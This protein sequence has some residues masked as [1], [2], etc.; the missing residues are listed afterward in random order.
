MTTTVTISL[1]LAAF[2]IILLFRNLMVSAK[3][4]NLSC[5]TR[6]VTKND[7]IDEEYIRKEAYNIY[8][9]TGNTNELENWLLAKKN[10]RNIR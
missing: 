2:T 8:I 9:K 10:L 7:E 1:I 3:N 4:Y 6:K 5:V